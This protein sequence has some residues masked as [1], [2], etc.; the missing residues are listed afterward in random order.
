MTVK[1]LIGLVVAAAAVTVGAAPAA[2]DTLIVERDRVQCPNADHETI[3][4]A[5]AAADLGDTIR[6]CPD[7]YTEAVNVEKPALRLR[8]HGGDNGARGRCFDEEPAD[9]DPTRDAIVTGGAYSFR[10]ARDDIELEHFVVQA[11]TTGFSPSPPTRATR[12]AATS[13]STTSA[14]GSTSEASAPRSR[15]SATTASG[16]TSG[17]SSRSSQARSSTPGSIT[18]RP[19]STARAASGDRRRAE[20][21]G[22][23]RAQHRASGR[24]GD[25]G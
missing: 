11:R 7:L 10:L 21:G 14:P 1:A 6:V 2:A 19:S 9:P 3:N 15:S 16:R 5:V 20:G 23:D 13:C 4:S 22:G 8:A 17:A 18:T 12:S 25:P 24:R